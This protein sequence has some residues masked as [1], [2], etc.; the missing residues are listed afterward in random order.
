VCD[1]V[2]GYPSFVAPRAFVGL[3]NVLAGSGLASRT[4][5]TGG[6]WSRYQNSGV[7]VKGQDLTLNLVARIGVMIVV[8]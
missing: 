6:R 4:L 2:R 3:Q 7:S 5:I 1:R 8:G